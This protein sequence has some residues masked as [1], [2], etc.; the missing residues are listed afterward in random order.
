M[1]YRIF[2]ADDKKKQSYKSKYTQSRFIHYTVGI[3]NKHKI[4]LIFSFTKELKAT[5]KRCYEKVLNYFY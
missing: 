5:T 3:N 2:V 1:L 4:N